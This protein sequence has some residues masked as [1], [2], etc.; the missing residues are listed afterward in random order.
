MAPGSGRLAD[1]AGSFRR[2]QIDTK[3][4]QEYK[5]NLGSYDKWLGTEDLALVTAWFMRNQKSQIIDTFD[6]I[7][8]DVVD[9]LD[10][11][12]S[13]MMFQKGT[14]KAAISALSIH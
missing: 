6:V 14:L 13:F 8:S 4:Y 9:M 2:A 10:R 11:F 1:K 12:Y 5:R 3:C 7:R